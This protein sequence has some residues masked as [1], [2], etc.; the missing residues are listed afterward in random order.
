MSD[1]QADIPVDDEVAALPD[2]INKPT[3]RDLKQNLD[4][5]ANEHTR[6]VSDVQRWRDNL[7]MSGAA[8]PKD[9]DG[10]SSVAPKLIRKQAEW[11]YS[12]LTE[13]F[14]S[15][16]DLFNVSPKTAGDRKRA[17]Q[18]EMVLNNQ[19]NTQIGKIH[20]IDNYIREAVD[21]GTVIVKLAW[22]TEEEKVTT[23]QPIYQYVP[24][25]SDE[26]AQQYAQLI[27]I[28]QTDPEQYQD[29]STIGLDEALRIF[30]EEHRLVIAQD[31]GETEEITKIVE[32]KNQPVIEVCDGNNI[33]I[34]PSCK[35]NYRKAEFICEIWKSSLSDLKKDGRYFN[36]DQIN[37]EGASPLASADYTEGKD[38][39]SFNFT[40]KARKQFLIYTYWGS[41]DTDGSGV[42]RPIVM[43]W[44][45]DVIIQMEDNPCPDLKPPFIVANYM[46]VRRSMYG[47]PDGELL[48]NSQK[49]VGALTR[50]MIDLMG[51]SAN[52]QTG[53]RKDMLDSTNLRKFKRGDD[54]YYNASV[55]DPRQGVYM[56]TYPEIPQSAYNML[57]MENTNADSL[58]GI[59]G[60][61]EGI[62]GRALGS[63]ATAVRG[64]LDAASK[65]ELAILRRLADGIIE[66]GRKIISMNAEFLSEKEVIR[67]TDEEFITVRRDDLPG[68]FDLR[69][70]IST[71]EEDNQKAEELAFILQ[72]MTKD[73]DPGLYKMVLS[74]ICRLRKMP[75]MQKKIED[76]QPQPDPIAQAEAQLKVK[77]LEVQIAKEQ[78][79][80]AKHQ[81]EAQLSMARSGKETTQANLNMVKGGTEQAKARQLTSAAD[82]QDL[83]YLEQEGGVH[84][85]R[86]LQKIKTKGDL[87]LVKQLATASVTPAETES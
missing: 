46:P 22:E 2:W 60:F 56:H 20:F 51:R 21:T 1:I 29:H 26:L 49:I 73:S 61:H 63:T 19:F 43:S 3:I 80:T 27:N 66:V 4:D 77:L 38:N 6:H 5:G 12:S 87:E 36:L 35:G 74:D 64:A 86:D 24:S 34:D 50:G 32:I 55:A 45:N 76:Y 41:W 52:S 28:Q 68:N 13:P 15:T 82:R 17:Q 40:D 59:K 71:A 58:T 11:R 47:E 69:L 30:V 14:L 65:R 23:E 31:T 16:P 39:E 37:V 62:S 7:T 44:V 84:Q 33:I 79:L 78:A 18:N 8:K 25:V 67:I 42:S 57:T 70:S 10:R 75:D 9:R 72:T 53:M 85:E 54:Y 81:A 48:E 83:D